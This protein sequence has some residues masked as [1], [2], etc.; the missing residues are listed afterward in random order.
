MS[1]GKRE[2][3]EALGLR[4]AGDNDWV[5]PALIGFGA[6]ACIGAVVALALAPR[7]GSELRGELL[8]RSRRVIGRARDRVES[9]LS[10]AGATPPTV[11]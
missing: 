8:S 3:L 5:G 10:Q 11:R 4:E 9:E 7:A 2:I 1:F 6:G